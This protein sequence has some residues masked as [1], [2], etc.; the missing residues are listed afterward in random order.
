MQNQLLQ[1]RKNLPQQLLLKA[2]TPIDHPLH[3]SSPTCSANKE[4]SEG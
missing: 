4:Q 2:D 1:T 3:H